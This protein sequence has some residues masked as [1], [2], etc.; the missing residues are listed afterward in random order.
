MTIEKVHISLHDTCL[1]EVPV[2]SDFTIYNLPFGVFKLNRDAPRVG[3][4][5]GDFIVDLVKLSGFGFFDDITDAINFNQNSL[6]KLIKEGKDV[7]DKIRTRVQ[8][9]LT[10][11]LK[12]TFIEPIESVLV[13]R[14][15]VEMLLPVSIGDYTDFYSSIEHATN[16]GKLFRSEEA[17][18]MPNWKHLPVGYHGR[19]SSIITS[20]TPIK[21]PYGQIVKNDNSPVL[22][23]SEKLDFELEMAFIIGKESKLGQP[24]NMQ[25]A[26]EY[27]F[28]FVLV[29]DWSARDIQ[30]WEYKPLGPFLGK[31]FATSISPWVVTT[32]ALS[33]FVVNGP[34]QDN[35]KVLDYL[36][37][38]E[39]RN[40]DI[41]LSVILK[42][43]EG[44]VKPLTKTNS[45]LLYWSV[46]QQLVHH[47]ING[48]N[49]RIGDLMASG[50]ISGQS[51]ETWGSLLEQTFDG[52]KPILIDNER[53]LT[54][55]EDGD[56][57]I[58]SGYAGKGD[59]KVGFGELRNK[60][61][62]KE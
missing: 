22:K 39:P 42:T 3:I 17:A 57:I 27:I 50:T 44:K 15:E 20:N 45:K 36:K 48:C 2:D 7:T 60:I 53:S 26:L 34:N 49:V 41:S 31:S 1:I 37:Q 10:A 33:E 28:G 61:F 35:P 8:K 32:S 14:N 43:K 5:I 52:R 19:A 29:N 40:Y 13:K 54:F 62:L 24:I 9:L 25:D 38:A 51:L 21:R 56:E 4:A 16:V 47:T 6:N 11:Q 30:Q 12:E 58:I 23:T 55:L 46:A 18:L 59:K